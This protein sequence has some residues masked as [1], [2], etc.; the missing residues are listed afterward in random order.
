M[1][2]KRFSQFKLISLLSSILLFSAGCSQNHSPL[3]N[4][5]DTQQNASSAKKVVKSPSEIRQSATNVGSMAT[6]WQLAHMDNF[7]YIPIR[8]RRQTADPKEWM[9]GAFYIGL[10]EWAETANDKNATDAIIQHGIDNQYQLGHRP[11]HGD[12]HAIG[13]SYLWLYEQTG[14]KETYQQ[15][16][17][18][19]D[20]ILAEAPS[21]SLEFGKST[22]K[23]FEGN[24]QDRWCWADAL[25]M[26]PRTW[27]KL[28]NATGDQ[29]YLDYANKEYWATVD[30]LFS[31]DYGLFFRDSRYFDKKS[32][33]GEP[34]F[35]SRGN[36]WVFAALPL[37]LNDLPN[38]FPNRGKYLD[39][40]TKM[41]T[42]LIKLQN[43]NG[44]W[45]ASLR[46]ANKVTTPEVSGTAFITYG[47]AWGVNNGVLS[48]QASI[49]AVEKGW[50]AIELAVDQDGRVNWVQQVGKAPDPVE[51]QHT[52]LYGVGAV[53]LAASEMTKWQNTE[54]EIMAYG[55]YV[56]ERRDDFA[57]ENDKVAFRVYGPAAPLA[58]HSSGVDAWFKKVDYSIIDKWYAAHVKGISYHKDRGEG[59]DPYHTG[60]SRGV[61]GSSVWVDGKPY[62]AHNYIDYKVIKSGG[63]EVVFNLTYEWQTPLGLVN[64]SKTISLALGEHLYDVE[65]VFTLDGQPASL[66]IAIGIATH[67]EKAS[68]SHNKQSGRISAWE[69]IDDLGVGTAAKIAP[70]KIEDIQHIP[71]NV[72][73]ESHIWLITSSDQQGKLNYSAGFA[74]QGAGEITNMKAWEDYLDSLA[75][76]KD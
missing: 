26:A 57:W 51:P 31:D 19:F 35:W 68:V 8:F 44:Y 45:P 39:L 48:D 43:E 52:Q 28:A 34:V 40:Y 2:N 6:Q 49:N 60:V 46:D 3:N 75:T 50:A 65:S 73:D 74:W 27:I 9:Q 21:N 67:D 22:Q 66:P 61:G 72:K 62:S 38:D 15:I 41:A 55:R 76:N 58:G 42:S 13:Q 12:D 30:Y 5:D 71:S 10:T 47:L 24:C 16:K 25:F 32:D 18:S 63:Q 1:T 33:N 53:L 7:D 64:E 36:G 29:R 70:N 14:N 69:V 23:G 11:K 4:V 56:P 17:T 37:I 54:K 20:L 59:Y